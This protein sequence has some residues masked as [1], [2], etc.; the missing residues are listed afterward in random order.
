MQQYCRPSQDGPRPHQQER[1][2]GIDRGK[3]FS[4]LCR[5][6]PFRFCDDGIIGALSYGLRQRQSFMKDGNRLLTE[7]A[8]ILSLDLAVCAEQ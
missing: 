3:Q 2:A 5:S 6:V 1:M 7:E 4:E 8:R